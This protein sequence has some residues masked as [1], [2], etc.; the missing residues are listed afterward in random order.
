MFSWNRCLTIQK[1]G[2]AFVV[3]MLLLNAAPV[4]GQSPDQG[5]FSINGTIRSDAGTAL[6]AAKVSVKNT[7]SGNA[8]ALSS[9]DA[10]FYEARNLVAGV[11]EITVS[12]SGYVS[13]TSTVS[14]GVSG[15]KRVE[16]NFLLEPTETIDILKKPG[17]A[18]TETVNS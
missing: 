4:F 1:Q 14:V 3:V 5:R 8:I 16:L 15:D 13:R 2:F 11:Y 17:A 12:A 6:G 10:G 7:S 18:N 9:T